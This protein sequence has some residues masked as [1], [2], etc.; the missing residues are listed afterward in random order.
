MCK[1][2]EE[3]EEFSIIFEGAVCERKEEFVLSERIVDNKI[4]I[5][6]NLGFINT[7]GKYQYCSTLSEIKIN[8]CPM[9]GRKLD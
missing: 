3:K 1:Y 5:T 7:K 8:F 9:C 6:A 4:F 2:C